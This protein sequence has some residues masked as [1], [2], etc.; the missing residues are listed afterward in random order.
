MQLCGMCGINYGATN[1]ASVAFCMLQRIIC[2]FKHFHSALG[3]I[4]SDANCACSM[5]RATC[6]VPHAARHNTAMATATPTSIAMALP[7]WQHFSTVCWCVHTANAIKQ[8]RQRRGALRGD[9][10]LT[11]KIL[12][13][14]GQRE[15]GREV[16]GA[17]N[18]LMSS[19]NK[20]QQLLSFC[21]EPK[22]V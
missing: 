13:L 8:T 19:H 12:Q 15:G 11:L 9:A 6:H 4:K 18:K 21:H 3:I 16:G 10:L 22:G 2:I 1:F 20:S 7:D 14:T 5:P 17:L